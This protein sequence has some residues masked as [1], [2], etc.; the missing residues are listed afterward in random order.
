MTVSL[1]KDKMS[2][3]IL[4][5]GK[6]SYETTRLVESFSDRNI[7]VDVKHSLDFNLC[8]NNSLTNTIKQHNQEYKLPDIVL[9]RA[10][11]GTSDFSLSMAKEFE[12]S[13]VPV[14]N[15]TKAIEIARNKLLTYFIEKKLKNLMGDIEDF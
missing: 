9:L 8:V 4:S 14:I 5:K 6:N 15:N 10:G 11:A 1:A 13:G 2:V 12:F 7:K 3:L